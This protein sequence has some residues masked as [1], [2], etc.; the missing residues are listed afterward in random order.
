MRAS[1]R[2]FVGV[3]CAS[4]SLALA[5]APASAQSGGVFDLSWHRVANGGGSASSGGVYTLGGTFGQTDAFASSGGD[6]QLRG[7]FWTGVAMRQLVDVPESPVVP[8][9]RFALRGFP[10]NPISRSGLEVTFSLPTSAPAELDLLDVG[11]RRVRVESVGGLG[12]GEHRVRFGH[13]ESLEPGI[14]WLRLRQGTEQRI[15]KAVV[16]D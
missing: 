10:R 15:L 12:P 6:Y 8:P 3:L 11:G 9:A 5:S 14:Y 4:L 1:I 2:T 13:P 16:L 7:G